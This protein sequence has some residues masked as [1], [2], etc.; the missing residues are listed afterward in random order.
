MGEGFKKKNINFKFLRAREGDCN[1][2]GTRYPIAL[3]K[4]SWYSYDTQKILQVTF[5]KKKQ[6]RDLTDSKVTSISTKKKLEFVFK[7]QIP[8]HLAF[9]PSPLKSLLVFKKTI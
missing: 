1:L 3:P 5:K 4:K 2:E 6:I 8:V 7:K 9:S